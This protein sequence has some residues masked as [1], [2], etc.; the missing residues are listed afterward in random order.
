MKYLLSTTKIITFL[1]KP[2]SKLHQLSSSKA[3][4]QLLEANLLLIVLLTSLTIPNKYF[5]V[6]NYW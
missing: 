2:L 1:A 4:P 3:I 5:L 6:E